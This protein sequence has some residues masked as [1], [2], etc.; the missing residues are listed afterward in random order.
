MSLIWADGFED[1]SLVTRKYSATGSTFTTPAGRNGNALKLVAGTNTQAVRWTVP[2]ADEHATM[3]VG[4]AFYVETLVNGGFPIAYGENDALIVFESDLGATEHVSVFFTFATTS[5]QL[6][7]TRATVTLATSSVTFV[8]ETWY[9]L[10]VKATLGD[11]TSGSVVV[12]LNGVEIVNTGGV[13]TKNGGTDTVFDTIYI[14]AR[15]ASSGDD[16]LIDDLYICNGAGGAYD[17]FLGDVAVE[18]IR[19]DGNGN[20]SQWVGSDADSTDNY[21]LVDE[22]TYSGADYVKSGTANNKDLYTYGAL[23]ASS[24]TVKGVVVHSV[25]AKTASGSQDM[26]H[27]T[28][29]GGTNYNGSSIALGTTDVTTHEVWEQSPA[30]ASDWSI[31]EVNGAEFGIEAL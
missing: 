12:N 26:R 23:A 1:A 16:I 25:A 17:D 29:V 15:S 8:P 20:S 30:T 18:V 4:F 5:G 11:G 7:V 3:I 27:I 9:Y 19:P 14:G 10:E 24:G 28:R 13:D 31:S 6:R 22:A 2:A 21:L